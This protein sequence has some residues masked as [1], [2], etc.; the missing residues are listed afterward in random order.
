[1]KTLGE[2]PEVLSLGWAGMVDSLIIGNIV[3]SMSDSVVVIDAEGTVLYANRATQDI[4]GF[5]LEDLKE[6][7]LGILFDKKG[8]NQHFNEIFSEAVEKKCVN[9]Y[10]EVDYLHPKGMSKRLAVT[11]SY[12]MAEG[13]C[14]TALVGFVAVFRDVTEVFNLRRNERDLLREKQRIA[15]EKVKSLDRLAMG[16]AHEIRNPWLP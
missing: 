9:E 16:V 2:I 3:N 12:L 8:G 10:R 11:T 4:L 7:G 6:R 14:E 1:M 13:V 5:S 15:H